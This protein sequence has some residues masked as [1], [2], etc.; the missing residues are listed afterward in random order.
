MPGEQTL[1]YGGNT[2]CHEVLAGTRQLIFDAGTGIIGLGIE[3]AESHMATHA[4]IRTSLFFSH[5]HHDHTYGFLYFKPVYLPSTQLAIVGPKTYAGS[6][7]DLLRALLTDPFHP[8]QLDE[9]GMT[10]T[11]TDVYGGE[12]LCFKDGEDAMTVLENGEET[13]PEDVVVRVC[14]NCNHTKLGVLHYRVEYAGK[15]YVFATDVEGTE[16]GEET[17]ATFA[18]GADLLAHDAQY[19]D[20]DYYEGP[21]PRRGWGHSTYRMACAT[22]RR[23]GVKRLAIIHHEP[24]RSDTCLDALADEL[25]EMFPG[26][27]MA[28]EGMEIEL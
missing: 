15:S 1:R 11:L 27:F 10:H 2:T 4:P 9:M 3:M 24:E 12:V 5:A 7:E 13:S 23:A 28:K 8:V 21:P 25:Q 19:T 16:D 6:M 20:K 26:A 18:E 14:A 22:A 17:L